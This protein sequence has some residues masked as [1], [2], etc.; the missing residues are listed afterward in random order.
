VPE[1]N[2][3]E[4]KLWSPHNDIKISLYASNTVREINAE[5]MARAETAAIMAIA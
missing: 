4:A 2:R 3:R 5:T 1:T